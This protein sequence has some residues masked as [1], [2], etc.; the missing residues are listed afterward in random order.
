MTPPMDPEHWSNGPRHGA[1]GV[2]MSAGSILLL[3]YTVDDEK[4]YLFPGGGH[5][6]GETFLET[7]VREVHE[8]TGLT[9]AAR[10]FLMVHEF[11]PS[12]NP[13]IPSDVKSAYYGD[14]HRVDF[15]FLCDVLG[16]TEPHMNNNPDPLHTGFEW[17]RPDELSNWPV[18]P[19]IDDKLRT[20]LGTDSDPL[21]ME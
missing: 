1:R 10:R 13:P 5:E 12:K 14:A 8:E 11:Q 16:S 9:V 15:Y 7:A 2:V 20:V 19:E 17:V 6:P 3:E 21:L 4:L 18:V